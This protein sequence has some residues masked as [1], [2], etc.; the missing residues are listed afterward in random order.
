MLG[1]IWSRTVQISMILV[2]YV[3]ANNIYSFISADYAY[4]L[5]SLAG[6]MHPRATLFHL[7]GSMHPRAT[8]FHTEA[9]KF[10][11]IEGIVIV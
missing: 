10:T 4:D 1:R 6:S 7:A 5:P 3:F 2:G 11:L 9:V 8:M